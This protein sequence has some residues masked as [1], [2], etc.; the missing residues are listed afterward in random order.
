MSHVNPVK[1]TW[2][3]TYLF[4]LHCCLHFNGLFYPD[5]H[6]D[7]H[8]PPPWGRAGTVSAASRRL[9]ASHVG[10]TARGRVTGSA[11]VTLHGL[12]EPRTPSC[13]ARERMLR[14]ASFPPLSRL[15]FPP[16]W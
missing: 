16:H 2:L 6:R 5:L 4:A 15:A 10:L 11:R 12:T 3:Q 14:C 8:W 1:C 13:A 9:P 7:A